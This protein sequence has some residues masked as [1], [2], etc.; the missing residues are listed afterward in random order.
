M[1]KMEYILLHKR[2]D[3]VKSDRDVRRE[4]HK[5]FENVANNKFIITVKRT[6]IEIQYTLQKRSM[7]NTDGS[8]YYLT[9]YTNGKNKKKAIEALEIA[10]C[11]ITQEEEIRKNYHV[12]V[13][14]DDV[15][16]Y[17]CVK[18]YPVF[19]EYEK[20]IR[21]LIYKYLTMS[22]GAFWVDKTVDEELKKQLKGRT[23]GSAEKLIAQALHEM[24]MSHLEQFLF[25]PIREIS[26]SD[27]IDQHLSD[28]NIESMTKEEIVSTIRNARPHSVWDKY[29]AAHIDIEDLQTKMSDIRG[30]RNKVAHCKS[31]YSKEFSDSMRILKED[32][33]IDK[34]SV[35][36]DEFETSELGIITARDIL[37]GLVELGKFINTASTA[38]LSASMT[39]ANITQSIS[40]SI[41][42]P[43]IINSTMIETLGKQRQISPWL[44]AI[45]RA[46]QVNS[47]LDPS[48]LGALEKSNEISEHVASNY[49]LSK[50]IDEPFYNDEDSLGNAEGIEEGDNEQDNE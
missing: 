21:R 15:S 34:L 19:H 23:G 32:G 22:L 20:Q 27:M 25:D 35:A 26:T 40:R 2:H 18:A 1:E 5:A 49:M 8:A 7:D 6:K 9:L 31:F 33:L 13:L 48:L 47:F 30:N 46:E 43:K 38:F 36:I 28:E 11:K 42:I 50:F 4:V 16:S 39:F 29:F 17:Y 24:D 10:H 3:V 45:Q 41:D 14:C 44:E 12:V 37:S